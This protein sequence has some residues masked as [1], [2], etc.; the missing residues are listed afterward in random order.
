[1]KHPWKA[2][3][4]TAL[5]CNLFLA[6]TVLYFAPMEVYVGNLS[7]FVMPFEHVWWIMLAAT[8]AAALLL[9]VV[10]ML[11]PRKVTLLLSALTAG[12]ALC[13][14]VQ[15]MFLN[16]GMVTLTGEEMDITPAGVT[17]NLVIWAAILL[18]VLA[19]VIVLLIK[20]KEQLAHNVLRYVSAALTGI[21]ALALV[22]LIFTSDLSGGELETFL[23]GNGQFELSKGENVV[24]F[25]LDTSDAS[26]VNEALAQYPELH[27]E[28]SGFTYYPN[29]TSTYSRTFPSLTYMLT[30]ERFY[31]NEDPAGYVDR[32]FAGGTLLRDMHAAGTDVRIF[33][34]DLGM[35]GNAASDIIANSTNYAYNQLENLSLP[36]LVQGMG[37]ISLYKLAP[38]ALKEEFEYDAFDIGAESMTLEETYFSNLDCDFYYELVDQTLTAT[39]DYDKAFRFY[40]LWGNHPG[41]C[42]DANLDFVFD[43]TPAQ[44]DAMCGSLRMV[45]TYVQQMKALGVY[46]Q[47]TVIIT[48][49]HGYSGGGDSLD[50]PKAAAPLMMIKPAGAADSPLVISNAPVCHEDLPATYLQGLGIDAA[51]YGRTLLDIPEDEARQRTYYYTALFS[52]EDGEIAL[53][54]YLVDGN[55]L[56]L[57]SYQP[58]DNWWDV[59]YSM[60]NVSDKSF[61]E[62]LNA[63]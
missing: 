51:A 32:A 28:L 26:V 31:F 40:H 44:V 17:V 62:W 19:G 21:Q 20:K 13:C 12:L 23:T 46:D 24:V 8:L 57:A 47:S 34:D 35:I 33:T 15:S 45:V 36:G 9:T 53:R 3:L 61:E 10:E 42:W 39:A 60:A 16:G 18:A 1:M 48:A 63:Q 6:G 49:D 38:Y 43:Y 27:N 30:G 7:S 22:T 37:T 25:I 41:Y 14:Y 50:L 5:L 11:L 58:T 29:T 52:D 4:L 59:E 55:A 54:E 2:K 56:E